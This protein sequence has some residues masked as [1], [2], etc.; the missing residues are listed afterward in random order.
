MSPLKAFII[1]EIK[2]IFRDYRTLVILF[3]MP[4]A[5]LL[6]FGYV[7]STDTK[8]AR[9]GILDRANDNA[10]KKLIDK[11]TS[12]SYFKATSYISS[13][14]EIE[15]AFKR[16]EF[17]MAVIIENGFGNKIMHPEG[18][19]VQL[20]ADA[21][22]AN[23]AQVLTNY[24]TGIISNF[25][26]EETN[27]EMKIP[28]ETEVRMLYN[29]ELRGVYM[30]VPGIIAMV[31][32]LVSAM[33]TSISITREKE[34]GSM[35]V[36]LIS[37]L[38][39]SQII[40]GKV[41]PYVL[42]SLV[43]LFSIMFVSIFIFKVPIVGSVFWMLM[44]NFVYILLSLAIGIFIS[45]VAESQMI[46]MLMSIL[47]LML[48]TII[49]S[50]FLFPISSM[51]KLLQIISHLMPARWYIDASK[52]VMF[53]SGSFFFIWKELLILTSMFVLFLTLSI[54]KFNVRLQ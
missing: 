54:K 24:A 29:P 25:A 6:I 33:M 2:H 34:F 19:S 3:L 14:E 52:I 9:I 7:I 45:T 11:L 41:L 16:G 43:N 53:K 20:I 38:K 47:G 12:S 31:L 23:V 27:N 28:I 37:P 40:L 44:I 8:D 39:P 48:P 36:L 13:E 26:F 30:S 51:P 21:S 50:G 42:L 5:Q 18:A 32:I 22:D 17:F 15:T 4:I 46:A 1:K 35:E 49:L 10:S